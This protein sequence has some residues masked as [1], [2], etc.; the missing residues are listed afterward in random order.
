MKLVR[1]ILLWCVLL[2]PWVAWASP[3]VLEAHRQGLLL[4]GTDALRG[5]TDAHGTLS[6]DELH[7]PHANP[8][9]ARW[10]PVQALVRANDIVAR[11]GGDEF[12]ILLSD[13]L[14]P[15]RLSQLAHE[16][17]SAIALPLSYQGQALRVGVSIGVARSPYNGN[18]LTEL[19]R[20]ADEAMYQAKQTH[21]G[22][23]LCSAEAATGA[24]AMATATR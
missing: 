5:L 18:T 15:E 16:L 11:L 14:P 9:A 8:G 21:C 2:A 6:I 1:L 13:P 17:G 22:Y 19:M 24:T 4:N 23:V 12:V 7:G 20:H 3:A 10:G